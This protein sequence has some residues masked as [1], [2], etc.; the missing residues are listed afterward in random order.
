MTSDVCHYPLGLV[1]IF[2]LNEIEAEI[3]TGKTNLS[4]LSECMRQRFPNA[5]TVLTLGGRGAMYF[6]A[7][8]MYRQAAYLV[9]VA[10]TTAA[11]DTF[12][13]Y[14]L[15]E[16]LLSGDPAKALEM[17]CLAAAISVSRAGASDSIPSRHELAITKP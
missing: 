10:D 16:L 5:A 12:I 17:G 13:G 4:D 11:G 14:F 3:L 8:S 6:D 1:D 2:V 15:A 9:E 7:N